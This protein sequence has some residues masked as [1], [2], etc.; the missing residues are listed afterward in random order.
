MTTRLFDINRFNMVI[1][2]RGGLDFNSSWPSNSMWWYTSNTYEHVVF[3]Q[4]P[5]IIGKMADRV[6]MG[7]SYWGTSYLPGPMI[8]GVPALQARPQDSLR[9]RPYKIGVNSF[10][11]DPDVRD[12][13]VDL[14]GPV[15]S[16][17][18]PL[19]LGDQLVWSVFNGTDSTV[20]PT[21]WQRSANFPHLPVEIHQ[22]L[23]GYAGA[24]TDTSLMA[25][26]VFI[27]WTFI[28]ATGLRIDSCYVGLW[29]DLDIGNPL[30]NPFSIDTVTQTG[31][32]WDSTPLDSLN[33]YYS[34]RATGYTLLYGPRVPEASS[35]AVFCGRT[36]DGYRNLPLSSFWGMRNDYGPPP[37]GP[38]GPNTIEEA[39]NIA[40]GYDKSG[41]TI[42]D[43]TTGLPTRF[44]WS[45][46]PLTGT[47]WIY[48]GFTEGEAGFLFFSGPFTFAPGDTQWMMLA[49]L[50]AASVDPLDAIHAVRANA[51]RLRALSYQDVASPRS[52][53]LYERAPDIPV[54]PVLSQNYPNPFNES[55][56]IRFGLP[57]R[58]Y[59][60]L[61]VFNLL[62]QRVAELFPGDQDAGYHEIQFVATGL[63]SGV[64]F[65]RLQAGSYGQTRKLLLLR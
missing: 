59:V 63:A 10:A 36:V 14:G 7:A 4:G 32:C 21:D 18:G 34:P 48:S 2:D 24:R 40:R 33:R 62:G 1:T 47:G 6:A 43:P 13:P 8:G 53:S 9:Y 45:G 55:T 60:R 31:Y 52:L 50:P 28:N 11:T 35:K 37:Y 39:W 20:I 25:N 57:A 44:P 46:D 3:D 15:D 58:S 42:I 12:W 29:T 65:Y 5:W 30:S 41:Q 16:V 54:N 23:Y 56:T 49:L 19:L 38:V 22:S 51:A 17:G 61:E 64:Y 26:T 27:E